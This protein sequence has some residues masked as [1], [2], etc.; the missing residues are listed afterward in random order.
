MVEVGHWHLWT[1]YRVS[2]VS[3]FLYKRIITFFSP[4]FRQHLVGQNFLI[5]KASRSHSD[6]PHSTGFLWMGDRPD[7]ET[8]SWLQT[9][10]TRERYPWLP[11]GFIPAIPASHCPQAQRL[12]PRGHRNLLLFL[13]YN[14]CIC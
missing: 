5:I 1:R 4:M 12:R 9:T 6:T 2:V 8:S 13:W 3:Y 11:A 14:K 10:V 7:A